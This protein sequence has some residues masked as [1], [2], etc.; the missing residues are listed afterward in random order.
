MTSAYIG[1]GSNIQP[2][3]FIVM[4]L[5][6]LRQKLAV[7]AIS[8]FYRTKAV[9]TAE[10]QNDFINGVMKVK[11][12]LTA[13]QLKF[14][15]LR[16]IEFELG[17]LKEM[18]KHAPRTV[19]LDL[20]IFGDEIIPELN[21]PEADILSRPYVYVPLLDIEPKI[22]IPGLQLKLKKLLKRAHEDEIV[23]CIKGKTLTNLQGTAFEVHELIM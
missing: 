14:T 18:P 5:E 7:E 8:P 22:K 6:R 9:G 2:E 4:A 3:R 13:E 20:I 23:R 21:I 16:E 17:R 19:D 12:K 11:T 1:I 10:G 15:V